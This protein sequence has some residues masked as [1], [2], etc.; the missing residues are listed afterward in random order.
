MSWDLT[1]EFDLLDKLIRERSSDVKQMRQLLGLIRRMYGGAR[2]MDEAQDK[3]YASVTQRPRNI[4]ARLD[5]G[6]SETATR[7]AAKAIAWF[8]VRFQG[9]DLAAM[10]K[11]PHIADELRAVRDLAA[12]NEIVRD[13]VVHAKGDELHQ[14]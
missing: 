12:R 7:E 11:Y 1:E 9:D 6:D 4:L 13:E 8:Y 2:F 14:S 5:A 10:T 3:L